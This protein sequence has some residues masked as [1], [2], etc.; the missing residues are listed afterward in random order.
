MSCAHE[1]EESELSYWK[2]SL[3]PMSFLV[4]DLWREDVFVGEEGL[5]EGRSREQRQEEESCEQDRREDGVEEER[6]CGRQE[7]RLP[8]KIR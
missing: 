8:K 4:D 7:S 2:T 1:E 3:G 6:E 5:K